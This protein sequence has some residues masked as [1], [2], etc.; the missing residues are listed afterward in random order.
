MRAVKVIIIKKLLIS[1]LLVVVAV[2]AIV[3]FRYF[4]ITHNRICVTRIHINSPH[5]KCELI[6]EEWETFGGTGADIYYSNELYKIKIGNVIA[7]KGVY[8]FLSGSYE[9][10]WKDESI[11]IR[12][13][14]GRST[15]SYEDKDTWTECEFLIP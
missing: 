4:I 1:L 14:S 9:I 12:Y 3:G 10:K 13:Y 8:P 5:N 6:I 2:G 15:E 11:I 7:K